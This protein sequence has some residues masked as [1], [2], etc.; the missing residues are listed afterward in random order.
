MAVDRLISDHVR[1]RMRSVLASEFTQVREDLPPTFETQA[2]AAE[3]P[4]RGNSVALRL[5]IAIVE[6]L[7]PRANL[8]SYRNLQRA[9]DRS[10]RLGFEREKLSDL[11]RVVATDRDRLADQVAALTAT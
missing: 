4:L 3:T 7:L 8:T 11:L 10:D 2:L 9:L 6:R 5:K 1:R